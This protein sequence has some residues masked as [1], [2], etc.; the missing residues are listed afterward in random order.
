[1]L[2]RQLTITLGLDVL[3]CVTVVLLRRRRK[4][5]QSDAAVES[6]NVLTYFGIACLML[7]ALL[8]AIYMLSVV[9]RAFL[10]SRRETAA[11]QAADP[12]WQ[13]CL[14][15]LVCAAATVVLGFCSRPLVD[16][17]QA[18]ANGIY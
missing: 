1:M 14:P 5:S 4:A 13:M 11:E 9:R 8:T 10:P 7:S 15:L 17:F 3:F 18:V 12:G 16:F 2:P 6:G